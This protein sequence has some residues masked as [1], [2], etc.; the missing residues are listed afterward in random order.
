MVQKVRYATVLKYAHRELNFRKCK[1][2]VF[3]VTIIN[4]DNST[5]QKLAATPDEIRYFSS[6]EAYEQYLES[7]K[8][9]YNK[10][11]IVHAVHR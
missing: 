5:V 3:G 10:S 2:A 11:V 6:D 8:M 4:L 9:R 7:L 1:H